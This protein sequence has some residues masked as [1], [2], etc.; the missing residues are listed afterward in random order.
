MSKIKDLFYKIYKAIK[1]E[2]TRIDRTCNVCGVELFGGDDIGAQVFCPDCL[3]HLPK[4]DKYVCAHCGRSTIG[5]ENN[6]VDCQGVEWK[7]DMAR[8]PFY[9]APPVDKLIK[10]MK[11]N[12]K[13]YIAEVFQPFLV[14]TFLRYFTDVDCITFVPMT[15]KAKRGRGF[16]Q[17]E[18]LAEE[19]SKRVNVPV[20]SLLEKR[21]DTVRQARLGR[22]DRIKNLKTAFNVR[23]KAL[24]ENKTIL[25]VDDVLTTG[26][27]IESIAK[28]LKKAGAVRVYGLTIAS[29]TELR[30]AR[31]LGQELSVT[32]L[33]KD[34]LRRKLEKKRKNRQDF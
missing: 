26:A 13:R 28:V 23:N 22:D 5:P 14:K 27:T 24:I 4:N 17:S 33:R 6:C 18:R 9:Y 1:T 15:I 11:Y 34:K 3:E 19:L 12:N 29:V 30:T 31:A 10:D 25:V 7:F 21:G 8:S 20:E 16:N 2:Y 32:A